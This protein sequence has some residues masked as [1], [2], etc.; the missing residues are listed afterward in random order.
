MAGLFCLGGREAADTGNKHGEDRD[1]SLFLYKNEEIYNKGFEIW[2]QQF[3]YQQQQQ[4]LPNVT[5]ISFGAGPSRV[6]ITIFYP[7]Y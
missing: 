4:Q 6:V 2:P 7:H 5:N 3:Y 1:E